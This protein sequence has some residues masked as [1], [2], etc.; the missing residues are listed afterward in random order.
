MA[1]KKEFTYLV[2]VITNNNRSKRAIVSRTIQPKIAF[3]KKRNLLTANNISITLRKKLLK[4]YVWSTALY[5]YD[6]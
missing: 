2:S 4:T 3:N 1:H 5:G 6:T